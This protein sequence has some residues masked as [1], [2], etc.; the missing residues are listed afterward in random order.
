MILIPGGSSDGA[1]NRNIIAQY[2]GAHL[3]YQAGQET[4]KPVV[5]K[6]D[7]FYINKFLRQFFQLVRGVGVKF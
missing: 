3:N 7:F 4:S 6:L 2:C 5:S 1:I